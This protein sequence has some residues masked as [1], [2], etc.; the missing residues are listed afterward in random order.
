MAVSGRFWMAHVIL[1]CL[2]RLWTTLRTAHEEVEQGRGN[3]NRLAASVLA[4]TLAR[5]KQQKS[6]LCA[7][8]CLLPL[9]LHLSFE[10]EFDSPITEA[11]QGAFGLISS[12]ISL[13]RV[14]R[15][16][17]GVRAK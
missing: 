16:S 17:V 3:A 12:Y 8:L 7:D 6:E 13:L 11:C 15:E 5:M 9:T 10:E 2:H 4:R 1:G 14:W